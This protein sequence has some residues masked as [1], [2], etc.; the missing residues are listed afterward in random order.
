MCDIVEYTF[1]LVCINK[2]QPLFIALCQ[3]WIG[4]Q[5]EVVLLS[6]LSNLLNSMTIF[7]KV[8]YCICYIVYTVQP[9][10]LAVWWSMLQPLNFLLAYIC[11]AIPYQ[12]TKFKSANILAIAILGSTTKFNSRQY[13]RLYGSTTIWTHKQIN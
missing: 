2:L 7:T 10:N 9:E 11:M 5:D 8:L 6:V 3:I 13:F 4:F 1:Y 12:T